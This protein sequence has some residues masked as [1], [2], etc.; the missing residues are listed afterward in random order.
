[1]SEAKGYRIKTVHDFLIVPEDR[2]AV[3]LREFGV[4]LG[5]CTALLGVMDGIPVG[6]PDAFVWIDDDLHTATISVVSGT[7]RIV[8]ASGRMAEFPEDDPA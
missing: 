4:W 5:L 8:V 6:M 7:H 2:R 1:M 3:C